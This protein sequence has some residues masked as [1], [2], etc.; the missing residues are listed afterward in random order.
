[1]NFKN[2][3]STAKV[4]GTTVDWKMR[5]WSPGAYQPRWSEYPRALIRQV[6]CRILEPNDAPGETEMAEI[7]R[8]DGIDTAAVSIQAG[9]EKL[10]TGKI[11]LLELDVAADSLYRSA[12]PAGPS[13]GRADVNELPPWHHHSDVYDYQ[14]RPARFWFDVEDVSNAGSSTKG[15]RTM[16]DDEENTSKRP[17]PARHLL[18]FDPKA[19]INQVDV[20]WRPDW[21]RRGRQNGATYIRPQGSRELRDGRPSHVVLHAIGNPEANK[22]SNIGAAI[23][24]FVNKSGTGGVHYIV[25]VDGHVVKMAPDLQSLA[26]SNT[27]TWRG[28]SSLNRCAIGI[29]H[30]WDTPP[31]PFSKDMI[32][33]TADLL[34]SLKSEFAIDG[35]NIAGHGE[36]RC[37]EDKDESPDNIAV[38]TDAASRTPEQAQR[39]AKLDAY[40]RDKL[41]AQNDKNR[42]KGKLDKILSQDEIETR[43]AAHIKSKDLGFDYDPSWGLALHSSARLVSCPGRDY[44]WPDLVRWG[45]VPDPD[46]SELP[47]DWATT[48]YSGIFSHS[49]DIQ[50]R[51]QDDDTISLFGANTPQG[52]TGTPVRE[53]HDDM[54][55]IGYALPL[56]AWN[57]NGHKYTHLL[58]NVVKGFK[59]R[60]MPSLNPKANAYGRVNIEIAMM[61]KRVRAAYDRG[62]I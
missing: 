34:R 50:L 7:W 17:A 11:Y 46:L 8:Q 39:V 55:A 12:G 28:V 53:L 61:I 29:E 16:N 15:I 35:R 30:A 36:V 47:G 21:L 6:T 9:L 19:G 38:R 5:F 41:I 22:V 14:V 32:R 13:T 44:R 31:D 4:A 48:A 23:S 51:D 37:I 3:K 54:I 57:G 40:K 42:A 52:F 33:A 45:L 27:S 43:V 18:R 26:H 59:A 1:M 25:D 10:A 24:E 2:P 58:M 20:D 56:V 49:P 60:Y 62:P